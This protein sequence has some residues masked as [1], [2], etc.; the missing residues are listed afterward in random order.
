MEVRNG[1]DLYIFFVGYLTVAI[2]GD[3]TVAPLNAKNNSNYNNNNNN[4]T[5][6][7]VSITVNNSVE[8]ANA[9]WILIC[10]YFVFTMKTGWHII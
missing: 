2:R 9:L 6:A 7:V 4:N 10:A 3:Q 1:L 8:P 5:G